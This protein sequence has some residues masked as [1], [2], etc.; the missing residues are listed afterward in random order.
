MKIISYRSKT[1]SLSNGFTIIELLI[2]IAIIWI[3]AT[4]S[5]VSFDRIRDDSIN[6]Q[7]E[8]KMRILAE[9]LE[10]YYQENGEYP[11]CEAMS[12]SPETVVSVTLI[13]MNPDVL[14]APTATSGTNSIVPSCADVTPGSDNFAYLGIGCAVAYCSGY[15]LNYPDIEVAIASRNQSPPVTPPSPLTCPSG[16][17]VVP[18]STTYNTSDFCVMKYEAKNV[19]GVATSQPTLA[20]WVSIVQANAAIASN[21]ACAIGCHLITEAE[22]MTIAQNVLGVTSNWSTGTVGSGYVYRGHSDLVPPAAQEASANDSDGYY[23]TQNGTTGS[24]RRTLTLS[25]G[26]VIWDL[27]GNVRELTQGVIAAGLQPGVSGESTYPWREWTD[28]TIDWNGFPASA[29]PA[30]TGIINANLWDSAINGIGM[31]K[32]KFTASTDH[33]YARGGDYQYWAGSGVLAVDLSLALTG[34]ENAYTG[35]RVT[36]AP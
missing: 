16:F 8:S 14:T 20:P 12:A 6:S 33:P 28:A 10:K 36:Y 15:S 5:L 2:V 26:E 32:S 23:L 18:G 31:I 17:I 4:I 11:S 25:N 30:S 21:A 22:W 19:G 29:R 13:G 1:M 24:Q 7:R 3:L 27:A 9:T 35:F 34:S